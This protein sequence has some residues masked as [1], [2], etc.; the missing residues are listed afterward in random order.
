M[1]VLDLSS[2]SLMT[3]C[4][5]IKSPGTAYYTAQCDSTQLIAI[6][7]TYVSISIFNACNPTS[8]SSFDCRGLNTSS[9]VKSYNG[10][11]SFSF[12]ASYD[13]Q[14]LQSSCNGSG[15]N[16]SDPQYSCVR[17]YCVASTY[18]NSV[19]HLFHSLI[20]IKLFIS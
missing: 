20:I 5:C 13:T 15:V 6:Q 3:T 11:S 2:T 8:P 9:V 14:A 12:T 10:R 4:T 17:Y 19:T 1:F 7:D 16:L 18:M